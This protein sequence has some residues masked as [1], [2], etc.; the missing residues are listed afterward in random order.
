MDLGEIGVILVA[1]GEAEARAAIER[2]VRARDSAVRSMDEAAQRE[3]RAAEAI[4]RAIQREIREYEN[5]VKTASSLERA[6]EDLVASF[7]PLNRAQLQ[8][9]R[10]IEMLDAALESNVINEQQR[11]RAME[12]LRQRMESAVEAEKTADI[13]RMSAAM[14]ENTREIQNAQAAY[15]RLLGSMDPVLA[16][17]QKY[18]RGID[19]LNMAEAKRVITVEERLAAE[20]R[21]EAQLAKDITSAQAA[22]SRRTNQ[23]L[24]RSKQAHAALVG[25]LDRLRGS[26]NA[27]VRQQQ[28]YDQ[29][30]KTTTR[31]VKARIISE[32]EAAQVMEDV[33]QKMA[34]M[35]HVVNQN[36]EVMS[37][38]DTAYQRW[39]RGGLQ[40]A[41]YQVADFAVQVQGGTSAVVAFGQQAPQ[42]LGTFGAI[43][44]VIGAFVAIGAGLVNFFIRASGEARKLDDIM[45]DL[46]ESI[47]Q[48]AESASRL[49]DEDLAFEFGSMTSEV[50]RLTRATI[51][52]DRASA[53]ANLSAS[54]K[55]ITKEATALGFLDRLAARVIATRAPITDTRALEDAQAVFR[56]INFRE[57]GLNIGYDVFTGMMEGIS[58]TANSGDVEATARQLSD[59]I[60]QAMPDGLIDEEGALRPGAALLLQYRDLTLAAAELAAE[61]NGTADAAE[62]QRREAEESAREAERAA[63]AAERERRERERNAE[64]AQELLTSYEEQAAL[65]REIA[66]YGEKSTQVEELKAQQAERAALALIDSLNV[67]DDVKDSLRAAY[68][69]LVSATGEASRL[70]DEAARTKAE[71]DGIS[72]ALRTIQGQISS[73]NLS[74]VGRE[75]RLAA[76]QSGGSEL[77]ATAAA[78]IAMRRTELAPALGSAEGVIRAAAQQQLEDYIAAQERSLVIDEQINSILDERRAAERESKRDAKQRDVLSDLVERVRLERELLG[79]SEAERDVRMAVAR[80]ENR[81][82]EQAIQNA[83]RIIEAERAI[84]EQRREMERLANFLGSQMEDALMSMVDG[85]KSVE[86]AFKDMA[87]AVIAELYRVIVVQRIVGSFSTGGGGLLGALYGGFFPS[88]N[89]NVFSGGN[90]VPFADGGVVTRATTFPM[91][92]GGVGLMGEAGPEAILPLKRG[93]GGKLGVESS[94]G[95]GTVVNNN[96]SVTGSDSESVRREI[97]KMIPQISRVTTMAVMDARKRGGAMK[98]TFG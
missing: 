59:M 5:L 1:E 12:L 52:L 28:L 7:N 57:L 41:G 67:S 64:R 78:N 51:A 56:E 20:K 19:V 6:Y 98:S 54:I 76:L 48:Y 62:R 2:F 92:N 60:Q 42:L 36:G 79:V 69:E 22:Q 38:A 21:L 53:L 89:G 10:N 24:D 55:A 33:R 66:L 29:A 77:R 96:I 46:N 3:V 84:V 15:D 4:E 32:Q 70:T 68:E 49:R 44:A 65:Q 82:S 97:T 25:E 26:T 86:D 80:A 16:A 45:G 30:I 87:R 39:A 75:A 34:S 61:I 31:A 58:S 88:A 23:E 71:F 18:E 14:A 27:Q 74:N 35:G 72:S 81:Y 91:Q 17:N 9:A 11:A 83:I 47:D 37:R 93:P 85:T 40:N 90:V 63:Q 50:E 95:G 94:G 73:L 8:Y 13:K 43:G